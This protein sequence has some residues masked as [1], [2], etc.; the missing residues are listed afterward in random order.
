MST[1]AQ[2]VTRV[3]EKVDE[4]EAAFWTD[5]VINNQL[6]EAYRFYWLFII[7]HHEGYFLTSDNID[8]DGNADGEYAL[9]TD[10]FNS[11]LVSRIFSTEKVPLKNYERYDTAVTKTVTNLTFNLPTYRIKGSKIKFE[12]GPDFSETDAVELE[13]I[14]T[15]PDL[16]VLVNVDSEY[17]SVAEDCVVIRATIKCKEIEEMVAGEGADTAPFIRDLISCEQIL[18]E[19]LEQRVIARRYVEQF[20]ISGDDANQTYL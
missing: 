4:D 10:F 18:K 8:F 5:T 15:L 2:L 11:R 20:G 14:K 1:L 12:P 13:Y 3:R 7:R 17:P 9:P 6:N 19:A 16:S